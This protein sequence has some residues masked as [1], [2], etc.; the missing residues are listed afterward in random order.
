M[1]QEGLAQTTF[2]FCEKMFSAENTASRG[3]ER[4]NSQAKRVDK[5]IIPQ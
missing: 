2:R 3:D 1:M 5:K 4:A